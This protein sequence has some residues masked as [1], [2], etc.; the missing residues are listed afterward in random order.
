MALNVRQYSLRFE[1][2]PVG[3]NAEIVKELMGG[4]PKGAIYLP[5][6]LQNLNDKGELID[7]W[8]TP[9][10]FHQMSSDHMET[11]SAGPDKE[12]WTP[13]DIVVR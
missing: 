3:S 2:N 8:G 6:E 10:F 1:G 7:R 9:Y 13:D 5:P 11:R 4:N 12:L